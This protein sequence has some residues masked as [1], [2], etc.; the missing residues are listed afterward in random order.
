MIELRSAIGK[1][2]NTDVFLI[3][4]FNM[5]VWFGVQH[6]QRNVLFQSIKAQIKHNIIININLD[7]YIDDYFKIRHFHSKKA[8]ALIYTDITVVVKKRN[9]FHAAREGWQP[10]P[11]REP[12]RRWDTKPSKVPYEGRTA[13]TLP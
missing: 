10:Y 8:C 13:S 3:N 9:V 7:Y 2:D 4:I 6:V 5:F 1:H 12:L 11:Q